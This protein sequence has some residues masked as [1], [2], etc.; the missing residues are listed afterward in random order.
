MKNNYIVLFRD[1]SGFDTAQPSSGNEGEDVK[2]ILDGLVELITN[3]MENDV[4][5]LAKFVG[6]ATLAKNLNGKNKSLIPE[7]REE[8]FAKYDRWAREEEVR[9]VLYDK[10]FEWLRDQSVGMKRG[11]GYPFTDVVDLIF[12]WHSENIKQKL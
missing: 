12:Q 8:E 3:P 6:Y 11:E 9:R 5:N 4:L 2:F 10:I 1:F 7:G